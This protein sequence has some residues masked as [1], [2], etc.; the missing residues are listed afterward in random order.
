MTWRFDCNLSH[1]WA[2]SDEDN[3]TEDLKGPRA[4]RSNRTYRKSRVHTIK[5]HLYVAA[6]CKSLEMNIKKLL[7]GFFF[8]GFLETYFS[9]LLNYSGEWRWIAVFKLIKIGNQSKVRGAVMA[10]WWEHF[11][12]TNVARIRFPDSAS[13]VGWVCWFSTLQRKVFSGY[14]GFPSPQKPTFDLICFLR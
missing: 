8:H 1:I 2:S 11:P 6:F 14:S 13:Y 9:T 7:K 12:P 10:Q 5:G 3:L 4:G